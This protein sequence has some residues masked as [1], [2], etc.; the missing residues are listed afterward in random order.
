MRVNLWHLLP[1]TF[2]IPKHL[3]KCYWNKSNL[4]SWFLGTTLKNNISCSDPFDPPYSSGSRSGAIWSC[5]EPMLP[6]WKKTWNLSKI[7]SCCNQVDESCKL[8]RF[9]IFSDSNGQMSETTI[10]RTHGSLMMWM[11]WNRI[12]KESCKISAKLLATDG[13]NW[14]AWCSPNPLTSKTITIPFFCVSTSLANRCK[15]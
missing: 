12:G 15:Q 6:P 13:V 14:R 11:A 10:L 1:I 5:S 9:L 8:T 2:E 4:F 7:F 3:T